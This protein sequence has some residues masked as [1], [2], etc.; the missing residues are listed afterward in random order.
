MRLSESQ[1]ILFVHQTERGSVRESFRQSVA[2]AHIGLL[3]QP[4]HVNLQ[5][6][7]DATYAN[8]ERSRCVLAR[9]HIRNARRWRF[10]CVCGPAQ[11]SVQQRILPR[12]ALWLNSPLLAIDS[13]REEALAFVQII[14]ESRAASS[15]PGQEQKN[16]PIT[17][18]VRL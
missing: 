17:S 18:N 1:L 14:P 11:R 8:N 7:R 10:Y 13:C 6:S 9:T 4:A 2:S 5:L 3:E 16:A 12:C 15:W